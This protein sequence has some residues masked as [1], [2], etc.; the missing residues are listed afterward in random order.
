LQEVQ[1]P[2]LADAEPIL[3]SPF[4]LEALY[5]TGRLPDDLLKYRQLYPPYAANV[6]PETLREDLEKGKYMVNLQQ[7]ARVCFELGLINYAELTAYD[8]LEYR[9]DLLSSYQLIAL[10]YLLKGNPQASRPFLLVIKQ[11]LLSGAWADRY[12]AYADDPKRMESDDYLMSI[13]S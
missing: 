8:L 13:K 12:L 7:N 9:G 11:N 5:H 6:T 1:K 10:V 2:S 3:V 4:I